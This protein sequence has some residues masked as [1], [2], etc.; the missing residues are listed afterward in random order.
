M[1]LNLSQMT[2]M[3]MSCQVLAVTDDFS[4]QDSTVESDE[5]DDAREAVVVLSCL[6]QEEKLGPAWIVFKT[7]M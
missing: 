4:D 6:D 2:I 1:T 7:A 3:M 5:A